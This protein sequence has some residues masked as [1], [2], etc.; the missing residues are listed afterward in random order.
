MK[1]KICSRCEKP[2]EKYG[3]AFKKLCVFCNR[4]RLN[5]NKPRKYSSIKPKFKEASGEAELFL[6][7][8]KERKHECTN[9]GIYLGEEMK[10]WFFSHIKGGKGGIHSE[11][12]LDPTNIVFHCWDCHHCWGDRGI[13][14]FN[15]RKDINRKS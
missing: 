7:L 9:C 5:E 14:A 3:N 4:D 13:D 2:V 6:Q 11:L 8:W 15:A 1:V 12:R 10:T